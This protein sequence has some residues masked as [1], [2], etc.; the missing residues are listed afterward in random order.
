MPSTAGIRQGGKLGLGAAEAPV[1]APPLVELPSWHEWRVWR[2]FFV[3][4]VHRKA[5]VN[6]VLLQ[7]GVFIEYFRRG[8]SWPRFAVA[9]I[10]VLEFESAKPSVVKS[11]KQRDL[12]NTWLRLYARDGSLP[13][14]ERVSAGADRG[15]TSGS[16]VLH[17]RYR[18]AAAA[19]DDRERRHADVERLRPYR[20]GPLS[21]RLSRP[22][23]R[24][25]S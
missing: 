6:G 20:Q 2:D 10:A 18:R 7:S 15:R 23:A 24:A 21:R 1:P 3:V 5:L 19:P 8:R 17:R 25:R 9:G 12:L 16:R 14:I 22:A 4:R 13:R 11:I